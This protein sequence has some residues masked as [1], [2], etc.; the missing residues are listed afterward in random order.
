M[1]PLITY[2]DYLVEAKLELKN[3]Y[4][5]PDNNFHLMIDFVIGET[6]YRYELDDMAYKNFIE[7][8]S[9]KQ[10]IILKFIESKAINAW[11]F[12]NS[13]KTWISMKKDNIKWRA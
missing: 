13:K 6:P 8:N 5:R 11:S 3:F 2:D 1:K 10:S 12:N 9:R 7:T 4:M